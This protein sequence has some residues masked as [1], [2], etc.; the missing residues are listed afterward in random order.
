MNS[1]VAKLDYGDVLAIDDRNNG[2]TN[3]IMVVTGFYEK[4]H[5]GVK[6]WWPSLSGHSI[7]AIDRRLEDTSYWQKSNTKIYFIQVKS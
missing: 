2:N 3:P 6:Y 7:K 4:W 1:F 5:N